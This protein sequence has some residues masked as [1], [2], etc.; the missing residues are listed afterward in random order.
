MF[1][2]MRQ[3]REEGFTLIELLIVVLV[4]GILAA[5]VVF[6]LGTF[7]SDS[8]AAACKTDKKSVE[9]ALAAYIAKPGNTLTASA[10]ASAATAAEYSATI[11]PTYLK[12]API[13]NGYTFGWTAAGDVTSSLAAC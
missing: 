3:A 1:K 9:T 4:L 12:T 6:A 13:G 11:V 8:K 10:A 5:I 7:Q 2:Q